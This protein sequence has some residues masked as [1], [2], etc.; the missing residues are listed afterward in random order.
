MSW[1]N[2]GI[3]RTVKFRVAL[4][5]ALLFAFSAAV[6]FLLVFLYLRGSM[7]RQTDHKL[8]GYAEKVLYTYLT[9]DKFKRF[10]REVP[11][12][13]VPDSALD[14]MK[15]RMPN[16]QVLLA[17]ERTGRKQQ[18][19]RGDQQEVSGGGFHWPASFAG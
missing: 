2:R 3:F 13:H 4:W 8:T 10:D 7:L 11:L 14:A 16:L 17:F 12:D 18:Y 5:Y 9:N 15:R 19:G 6:S 1:N